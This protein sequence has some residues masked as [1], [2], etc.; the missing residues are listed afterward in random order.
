MDRLGHRWVTMDGAVHVQA[1]HTDPTQSSTKDRL[2]EGCDHHAFWRCDPADRWRQHPRCV[3]TSAPSKSPTRRSATTRPPCGPHGMVRG[4]FRANALALY[5]KVL[6]LA[7]TWWTWQDAITAA[8]NS[9][10]FSV[11]RGYG[12]VASVYIDGE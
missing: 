1:E 7:C 8:T 3:A 9:P 4:T 5:M 2:G 11:W 6:V 12:A 10:H